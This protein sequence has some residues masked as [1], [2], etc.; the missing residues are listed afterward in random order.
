MRDR[1]AAV[2]HGG[3]W[4]WICA[5]I[6]ATAACASDDG[7]TSVAPS[8]SGDVSTTGEP[9]SGPDTTTTSTSTTGGPA[10]CEPNPD[11]LCDEVDACDD[12]PCGARNSRFDA[13][14]CL[15]PACAGDV[16]CP[17]GHRCHS[18]RLWGG[19]VAADFACAEDP[20][21]MRCACEG[22]GDCDGRYCVPEGLYAPIAAT[23]P[24]AA[25]VEDGCAP[26]GRPAVDLV[27]GVA[28]ATCDASP[29]GGGTLRIAVWDRVAPLIPGT[30]AL[31]KAGAVWYDPEGDGAPLGSDAGYLV[32]HSWTGDVVRA[33]FE[34]EVGGVRLTGEVEGAPYCA[35][36]PIC[37]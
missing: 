4:R 24:G 23:P 29:G 32:V 14:G 31:R 8:S 33:R 12:E 20:A 36:A 13:E 10:A 15:R 9:S 26:L 5:L 1:G 30:Y 22:G 2:A 34:V 19:C 35:G 28:A 7:A 18:P 21:T 27:V 37:E 3:A 25:R 11:Y 6:A 16:D 17:E